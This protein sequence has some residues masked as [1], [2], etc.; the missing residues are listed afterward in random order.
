M[1]FFSRFT[2]WL[3]FVLCLT[4]V[5]PRV[6]AQTFGY[7]A[8]PSQ[9]SLLVS[10]SLTYTIGL[11]NLL[12]NGLSG[13]TV[14][15][16]LPASVQIQGA[17]TTQGVITTNGN[18]VIFNLGP[19][20]TAQTALMTVTAQPNAV[21]SI[22]NVITFAA[23]A[24]PGTVTTNVIV[25]VTNALPDVDLGVAII[26]PT[27][28]VI[29][30]DFTTYSVIVTNAGPGTAPSVILTNVLPAGVLLKQVSPTNQAFKTFGTNL[31]FNLGKLT[32]AGFC[33]LWN[34]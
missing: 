4:G 14:T 32:N 18:A 15:S 27:Q 22:A 5:C 30:N 9:S 28:A 10:N 25:N 20:L 23:N 12:F 21:G 11:T 8:T 7:S 13:V 29:T 33:R 26:P 3:L 31:V 34:L 19:L 24:I 16:T 1:K 17:T 6:N 2:L